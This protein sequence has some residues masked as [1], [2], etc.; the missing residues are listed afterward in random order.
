MCNEWMM[1]RIYDDEIFSPAVHQ[2]D[3]ISFTITKKTS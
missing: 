3:F 1:I 2:S